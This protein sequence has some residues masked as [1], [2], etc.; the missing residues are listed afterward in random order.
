MATIKLGPIVA[1]IRGKLGGT[2]FSRNKAGNYAKKFTQPNNPQTAAQQFFRNLFASVSQRWSNNLSQPERETWIEAAP[3]F[4]IFNKVGEVIYLSGKG[5]HDL[6]NS[7][8]RIIGEAF[9]AE[10]PANA[11]AQIVE[12]VS[13]T[14]DT[15]AGTMVLE[16]DQAVNGNN[17]ALIEATV[18]VNA[19]VNNVQ[20]LY[21]QI[22]VADDTTFDPVA[23][24]AD[25]ATEY[26]AV[27]GVLPVV[28]QKVFIR[29]T[30]VLK[31]SGN[32]A[33]PQPIG[34]LAV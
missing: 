30:T 15:T 2:I 4:P 24:T 7:T 9:I 21:K 3:T 18:G 32:R 25:F 27:F 33:V 14:P 22:A 26:E 10:A 16:L 5:L 13:F 34:E 8:L 29:I 19:G 20:N 11:P 23:F 31:A 6:L 28:G 12:V 17:K 1:D